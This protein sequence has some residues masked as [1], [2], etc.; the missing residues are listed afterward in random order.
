MLDL[1]NNLALV[2]ASR[3][4]DFIESRDRVVKAVQKEFGEKKPLKLNNQIN[5]FMDILFRV[6]ADS[7]QIKY[8]LELLMEYVFLISY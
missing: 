1:S 2:R 8:R 3:S 4:K 5:V 7:V 6:L